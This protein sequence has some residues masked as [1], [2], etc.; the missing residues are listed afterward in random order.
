[1]HESVSQFH[2]LDFKEGLNLGYRRSVK[3]IGITGFFHSICILRKVR[4]AVKN[5]AATM[6]GIF[7]LLW[8]FI[9]ISLFI[10]LLPRALPF[11]LAIGEITV[12]IL[13]GIGLG[14]IMNFES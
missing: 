2:R 4:S 13:A 6:K 1:M 14:H 9:A 12:A 8:L 3:S 5:N 10:F 7:A 11:A